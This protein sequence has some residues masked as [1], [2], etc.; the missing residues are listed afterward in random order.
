MKRKKELWDVWISTSWLDNTKTVR[1]RNVTS[2]EGEAI[3]KLVASFNH[4][5]IAMASWFPMKKEIPVKKS[6]RVEN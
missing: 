3:Q 4:G 1:A 6:S 2:E 5:Y